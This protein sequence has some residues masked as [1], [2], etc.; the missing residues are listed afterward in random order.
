M[1]WVSACA[2]LLQTRL[3]T[4]HRAQIPTALALLLPLL[5]S[6]PTLHDKIIKAKDIKNTFKF[7]HGNNKFIETVD[8]YKTDDEKRIAF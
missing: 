5:D 2:Q 6:K 4:L 8:I 7:G 1:Q 3:Y